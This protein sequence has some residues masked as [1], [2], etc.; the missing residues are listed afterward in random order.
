MNT[1]SP[2]H[3]WSTRAAFDQE[4]PQPRA[5][6]GAYGGKEG[7]VQLSV[8]IRGLWSI[9][10]DLRHLRPWSSH[11]SR[12]LRVPASF[13]CVSSTS[14]ATGYSTDHAAKSALALRAAASLQLCSEEPA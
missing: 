14:R 6:N 4:L 10:V 7:S 3:Q 12:W 2:S 5:V 13:G 8:F 9:C 1:D 11:P